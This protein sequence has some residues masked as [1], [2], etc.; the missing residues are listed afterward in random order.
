MRASSAG[1]WSPDGAQGVK[2]N[3]VI[4]V[5]VDEGEAVPAGDAKP[6]PA[7][8]AEGRGSGPRGRRAVAGRAGR[9]AE[10]AADPAQGRRSRLRLAA[11]AAHGAAG[12]A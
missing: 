12:G 1:S 7:P 8:A 9:R 3:D 11:G 6:A 2:V 5:L 4:A 10:P